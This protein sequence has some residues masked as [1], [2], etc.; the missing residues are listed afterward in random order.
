VVE[1]VAESID[2]TATALG[3]NAKSVR[4]GIEKGEI[5][6]LRIGRRILVPRWWIDQQRNGPAASGKAA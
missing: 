5:P 6:S 3:I 4:A 1:R 2:D